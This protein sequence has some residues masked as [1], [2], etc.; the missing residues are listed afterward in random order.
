M[1]YVVDKLR[2]ILGPRI[3][4]GGSGMDEEILPRPTTGIYNTVVLRI[5]RGSSVECRPSP[6]I[7]CAGKW[8]TAYSA[9]M[10]SLIASIVADASLRRSSSDA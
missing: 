7:Q 4:H 6:P 1:R 3:K 10:R 2:A 5:A 9:R 8:S